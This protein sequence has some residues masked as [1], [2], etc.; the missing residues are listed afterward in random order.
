MKPKDIVKGLIREGGGR[1]VLPLRGSVDY[2]EIE[3]RVRRV[4]YQSIMAVNKAVGEAI[5]TQEYLRDTPG[6]SSEA[7]KVVIKR[8]KTLK[9]LYKFVRLKYE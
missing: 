1:R 2:D 9:R 3:A 7:K 4:S 5:S 6:I 8:L